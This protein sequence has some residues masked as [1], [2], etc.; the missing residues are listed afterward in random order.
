M[1]LSNG[2]IIVTGSF[3]RYND[4][5][6]EGFMV[7]DNKGNLVKDYNNTGRLVGTIFDALEGT[8]SLGQRTVTLV[9]DIQS[10]S[11]K[12]NLGNIIRLTLLD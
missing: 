10:F 3:T 4:I 7:I 6:R 5:I 12:S 1:Q 11:G 8:N 9:G 2:M